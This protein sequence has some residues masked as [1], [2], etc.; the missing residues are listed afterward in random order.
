MNKNTL[1]SFSH[2]LI[3]FCECPT[4][5]WLVGWLVLMSSSRLHSCV[6]GVK[7][8]IMSGGLMK[9]FTLDWV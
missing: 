7:F 8:M 3:N 6:L 2:V 5:G 1:H 4:R 9:L